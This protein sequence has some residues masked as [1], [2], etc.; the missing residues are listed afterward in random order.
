[1][2]TP[3]LEKLLLTGKAK[4]KIFH[5]GFGSFAQLL[6]PNDCY[7]VIHKI[8]WNGWLNQK[9]ENITDINWKQFFAYNEYA[10]KIQS[11][12]ESP[13]YYQF[14]NEV[15]FQWF[16]NGDPANTLKLLNAP[17]NTAQFDDYIL[18]TPKKPIIYDTFI[19]AND[20]L[21]FT[22]LRNALTPAAI[23]YGSVTS[24]ANE[25][26]PPSGINGARVLLDMTLTGTGGS[27]TTI[28]PVNKK[29]D[30]VPVLPTDTTENY[31]Q[32]IDPQTPGD[33]G[34]LMSNPIGGIKLKYTEYVTNP[35][36]SFEYVIV[37][38]NDAANLSSL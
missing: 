12:K 32:A 10:L 3:I 25:K 28:N 35:L 33:N 29:C 19:T 27:S 23:N 13:L 31:C 11:D 38:K 30:P 26:N 36:I 20:Y 7:I 16:F 6:I 5:I 14:R 24:Y 17:I 8:Y 34:S 2:I 9:P 22:I 37:Q 4:N 15:N 21:N 18:M 1:M